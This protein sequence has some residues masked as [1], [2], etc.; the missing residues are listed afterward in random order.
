MLVGLNNSLERS[1]A[2]SRIIPLESVDFFALAQGVG[3][4]ELVVLLR[5]RT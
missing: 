5:L 2:V 1:T 4:G 3:G